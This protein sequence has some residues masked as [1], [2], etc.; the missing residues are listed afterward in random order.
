MPREAPR[1]VDLAD[2]EPSGLERVRKSEAAAVEE[3]ADALAR[4]PIQVVAEDRRVQRSAVASQLVAPTRDGIERDVREHAVDR[5]WRLTARRHDRRRREAVDGRID[6]PRRHRADD[7]RNV[8]PRE[9]GAA[10]RLGSA[11]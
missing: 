3:E 4:A 11:R 1:L 7:L 8:G 9:E 5:A 2:D 10:A 6:G